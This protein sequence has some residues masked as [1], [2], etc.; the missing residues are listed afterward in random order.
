MSF[1]VNEIRSQLTYGGARAN[2]FYVQIANPANTSGD[3]KTPFMCQAAELPASTLGQVPVPYF[4][5]TINVAGDRTFSPWTVTIMNDEDF[6]IKNA[7]E[8][9]SN[10]INSM[11]GNQRGFGGP[12][13]S[14]YKSTARITQL[15]KGGNAL[16]TYLFDGIF[17]LEVGGIGMNWADNDQIETFQVTFAYDWWNIDTSTT[18]DAGGQ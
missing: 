15:S 13:P 7:M 5:R 18:G 2:Q 4:G 6:L 11:R 12:E 17:P 16:R 8:E 14:R 3:L 9:W 10:K 1:D